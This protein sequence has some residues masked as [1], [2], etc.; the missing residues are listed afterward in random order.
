M[1]IIEKTRILSYV[2]CNLTSLICI[3]IV[4]PTMVL[5]IAVI[6]LFVISDIYKRQRVCSPISYFFGEKNGCRQSIRESLHRENFETNQINSYEKMLEISSKH[7]ID[8][9]EYIKSCTYKCLVKLI[10]LL[11]LKS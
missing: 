11:I 8:I 1:E 9:N 6:K 10:N 3:S 7:I 5:S 2:S 4:L